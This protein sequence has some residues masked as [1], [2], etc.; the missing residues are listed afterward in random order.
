MLEGAGN[1]IL[2]HDGGSEIIF[3]ST[4]QHVLI[5]I[6]TLYRIKNARILICG[7]NSKSPD[8]E[9]TVL[10]DTVKEK[11]EAERR[12]GGKTILRSGKGCTSLVTQGQLKTERSG[13]G[14]L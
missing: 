6:L 12:K 13:K 14:L 11:E 9:K 10:Q 2:I 7:H 3:V 4:R 1:K 8:L 5:R